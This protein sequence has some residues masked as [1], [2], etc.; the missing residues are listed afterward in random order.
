MQLLECFDSLLEEAVNFTFAMAV[1]SDLHHIIP[2]SWFITFPVTA[3]K[4]VFA[5]TYCTI[6]LGA[7]SCLSCNA[8]HV[9][10]RPRCRT[11]GEK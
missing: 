4:L 6:R 5:G 10:D 2:K 9:G 3:Y 1:V 11:E 7:F 8:Q